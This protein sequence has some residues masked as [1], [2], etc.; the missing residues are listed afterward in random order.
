M[1]TIK[2]DI[3]LFEQGRDGSFQHNTYTIY[4]QDLYYFW[5]LPQPC[6]TARVRKNRRLE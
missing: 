1:H 5:G 6:N 2:Y 4:T 3:T